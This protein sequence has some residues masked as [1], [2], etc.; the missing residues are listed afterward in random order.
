MTIFLK[1]LK[2]LFKLF[3]LITIII[4]GLIINYYLIICFKE[5]LNKD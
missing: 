4:Q 3:Y 5:K 2:L 1:I